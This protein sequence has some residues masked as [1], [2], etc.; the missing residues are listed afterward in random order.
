MISMIGG[1]ISQMPMAILS[2]R[3]GRRNAILAC[4]VIATLT[5]LAGLFAIFKKI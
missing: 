1:F 5:A 3:I 4:S 2:N